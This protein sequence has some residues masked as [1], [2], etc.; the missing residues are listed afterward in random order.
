MNPKNSGPY[1]SPLKKSGKNLTMF[2]RECAPRFFSARRT[3]DHSA[4]REKRTLMAKFKFRLQTVLDYREMEEAW[5]KDNYRS[6]QIE[7]IEIENEISTLERKR[8]EVLE[9]P[10][11]TIHDRQGA[12]D[13]ASRYTDEK[14]GYTAALSIVLQEEAKALDEWVERKKDAEILR[15][16]REKAELEHRQ[17]MEKREQ[18]ELDEWAT[19]RYAS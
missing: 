3:T 19:L 2:F 9:Q 18:A 10:W 7:R 14:R 6:K 15:K 4:G 5:A 16:L 1:K 11:A 12:E 8:L 13:L 17:L